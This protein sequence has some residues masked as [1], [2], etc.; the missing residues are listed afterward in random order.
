MA[1]YLSYF[2]SQSWHTFRVRAVTRD[3]TKPS[4]LELSSLGAEVVEADFDHEDALASALEG[5]HA[6]FCITNFWDKAD[7]DLE[8]KQGKLINKLASGLPHLETFIFSS[9][10]D[11]RKMDK[12]QFQNNLPYNAKTDIKEDLKT[13]PELW[14]KTVELGVA[15]YFQNWV[16]YTAVFGPVKVY[17]ICNYVFELMLNRGEIRT[18]TAYSYSR[19]RTQPNLEYL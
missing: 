19:C 14:K 1:K 7:Y 13:Y 16:K 8:V 15:Y 6:I 11:A 12:G 4:A 9:L 5:A 17:I 2:L 18:R 3:S 10:P